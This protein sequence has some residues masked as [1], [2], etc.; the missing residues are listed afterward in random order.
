MLLLCYRYNF[1]FK[2]NIDLLLIE[3][4]KNFDLQTK[5]DQIIGVF[6]YKDK[7]K[8]I[9]YEPVRYNAPIRSKL[10]LQIILRQYI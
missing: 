6:I 10:I 7:Y 9:I 1:N 4:D 2:I 5:I 3:I 8:I